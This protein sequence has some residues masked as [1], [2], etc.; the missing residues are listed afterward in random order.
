MTGCHQGLREVTKEIRL[1]NPAPL[2]RFGNA[3]SILGSR[4]G[5]PSRWFP[6]H[7]QR[8]WTMPALGHEDHLGQDA[9]FGQ[10][11]EAAEMILGGICSIP[12]WKLKVGETYYTLTKTPLSASW[13]FSSTVRKKDLSMIWLRGEGSFASGRPWDGCILFALYVNEAWL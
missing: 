7:H 11:T 1:S 3:Y 12:D 10:R 2:Q 4:L 8:W 9:T 5:Q 13:I 6:H